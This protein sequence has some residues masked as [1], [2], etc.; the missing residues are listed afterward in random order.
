MDKNNVCCDSK[1]K[2][3]S[4]DPSYVNDYFE[5]ELK[6]ALKYENILDLPDSSK[7]GN[8]NMFQ[9]DFLRIAEQMQPFM[10]ISNIQ[11]KSSNL[12]E[13]NNKLNENYIFDKD[14]L[15]VLNS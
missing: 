11:N 1:D 4:N 12:E 6:F 7:A 2:K 14:N 3:P 9:D 5:E 15:D 8:D 10:S 13:I